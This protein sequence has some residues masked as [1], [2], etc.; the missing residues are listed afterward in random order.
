MIALYTV[1]SHAQYNTKF[2][3]HFKH[4]QIMHNLDDL[5]EY[6]RMKI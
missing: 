2:N 5:V 1:E 4:Y 6:F 3:T